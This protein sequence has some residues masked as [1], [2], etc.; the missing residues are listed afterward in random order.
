M[1]YNCRKLIRAALFL[2]PTLG[3]TWIFGV[4]TMISE[5]VA[6]AWI[7]TI[8]NSIEVCLD[9]HMKTEDNLCSLIVLGTLYICVLCTTNRAGK[10]KLKHTSGLCT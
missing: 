3:V 1:M 6:F 2:L 5:H 7:F 4:M 8:L 10:K 9:N